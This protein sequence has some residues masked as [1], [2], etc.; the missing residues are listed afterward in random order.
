MASCY[1]HLF[2]KRITVY[3]DHLHTVQKSRLDGGKAVGSGYEEHFGQVVARFHEIVVKRIVLFR[4]QHFEHGRRRV[5][6]HAD[7][8][9]VYFIQNE[10]RIGYLSFFK[11]LYYTSRH[12]SDICLAVA[13]Y[14]G[15]V[16]QTAERYADVLAPKSFGYRMSERCLTHSW[17]AVKAQYWSFHIAFQFQYGYVFEYAFLYVFQPVMVAFEYLAGAAK[18]ELVL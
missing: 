3:F 7:G 11:R 1:L 5:S 8:E 6:L 9:F 10:H 4:I 16:P 2:L 18:V 15:F 12:S 14:F 17:R 13:A